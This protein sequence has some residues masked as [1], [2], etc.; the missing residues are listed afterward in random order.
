MM[1][2]P[3]PVSA[4]IQEDFVRNLHELEVQAE[5]VPLEEDTMAVE[6][7]PYNNRQKQCEMPFLDV[8]STAT[9]MDLKKVVAIQLFEDK[10]KCDCV[11]VV[12]AVES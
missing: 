2:L 5:T 11:S 9:V 8:P 1:N 4:T 3:V 12:A 6:L 7:L 10:A